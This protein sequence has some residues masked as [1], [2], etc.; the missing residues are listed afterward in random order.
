MATPKITDDDG[1]RAVTTA[2]NAY[3]AGETPQRADM[4]V[5]VRWTLGVFAQYHPGHA[6][7]VRVPPAG[8]VQAIDGPRHTRG[9]PPNVVEMEPKTWLQLAVG[10]WTWDEAYDDGLIRASGTRADLA[11]FLP[12]LTN[13]RATGGGL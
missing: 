13:A 3:A 7:E 2:V 10:E 5:A 6:V 12:F 1:L 11:E 4:M 8:A 9:T